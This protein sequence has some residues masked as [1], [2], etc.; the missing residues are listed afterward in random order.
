MQ[1]LRDSDLG[2]FLWREN[3]L[4]SIDRMR[5]S[6]TEILTSLRYFLYLTSF[7]G[8]CGE[9][10]DTGGGLTAYPRRHI[11]NC[12]LPCLCFTIAFESPV[13]APYIPENR[14]KV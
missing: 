2:S 4:L 14:G 3:F 10:N 11:M 9:N 13:K 7:P 6:L 1:S 5:V 8:Y 12:L